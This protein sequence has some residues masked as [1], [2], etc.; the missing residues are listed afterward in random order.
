MLRTVVITG[1]PCAGKT[2]VLARLTEALKDEAVFVPEA[3]TMLFELGDMTPDAC[4]QA[5]QWYRLQLIVTRLQLQLEAEARSRAAREGKTFLICDRAPFD[6]RAYPM[7]W[8]AVSELLGTNEQEGYERYDL[9]VHLESLATADP[10]RFGAGG[11]S[12]RYES[13][14]EARD[15]ERRA[16][17]AWLRHP[18]WHLAGGNNLHKKYLHVL[19]L[20]AE[21]D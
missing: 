3:A 13:L 19:R 10:D 17:N 18:N 12:L 2:T 6:N 21:L 20:I 11:N 7:G 15:L 14:E 5:F 8:D 1:G 4:W 16:R 9:V